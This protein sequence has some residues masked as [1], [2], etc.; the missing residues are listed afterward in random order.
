MLTSIIVL[1]F[2]CGA[3][4]TYELIKFRHDTQR[5]LSVLTEIIANNCTA[6][7]A[8]DD[9]YAA[10]EI[11]SA[12]KAKQHVLYANIYDLNGHLFAS[13]SRDD[14]KIVTG[15]HQSDKEIKQRHLLIERPVYLDNE[16]IGKVSLK[17]DLEEMYA[18]LT[19]YAGIAAAVFVISLLVAF[20]MTS[21]LQQ[22]ISKPIL[23]LSKIAKEVSEMKDY[24]IRAV[25]ESDDELG[26][27]INGFNEMLTQIQQRD[28]VLQKN[29]E[30]LEQRVQ[31]R[32]EA[33][34]QQILERKKAE[35]EKVMMQT[36][37]HQAQKMEA[38]GVLAGGVAHDFNNLLTAIQGCSNLAIEEVGED[39]VIYEDLKEIQM[40]TKRATDLT[41]QLLLF[42]RKQPMKLTVLDL[43]K[44]IEGLLSMLQRLLAEHIEVHTHFDPELWTI[45]GDR[46]TLEQ[47][48]MNLVVNA[49]DAMPKGGDVVIRTENVVVDDFYCRTVPEAR[50]GRFVRLSIS[51]T[52]YGMNK[53]TL[54]HVFEPFFTTKGMGKGTGLGLSVIYGIVME[55][56]GWIN[57]YSEVGKGSVFKIYFPALQVDEIIEMEERLSLKEFFGSGE[58]IL[59]VEDESNV[60]EFTKRALVKYGYKVFLGAN[61]EESKEVFREEGGQFDLIF[62]DVVLPDGNGVDLIEDFLREKP[63]LN[64]ILTSGYTENESN[65]SVISERGYPFLQKP[66]SLIELLRKI[67]TTISYVEDDQSEE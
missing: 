60:R 5:E 12:L 64:I 40:A 11:L 35:E 4:I 34:Q 54:K 6:A 23:H 2:V 3:F 16:V 42:S 46:G 20:G 37:L 38:I 47:T 15:S 32:T 30:E 17:Y 31:E 13:Y 43:N 10:E 45:E 7:L 36:Q 29:Q 50:I 59:V 26:V 14:L 58:R 56:N 25:K 44:T 39:H 57:V 51:D 27:L 48:V 21:R 61:A 22:I 62:S 9:Q 8:F 18:R 41:H 19:R 65:W 28:L 24:S 67:K 49:R 66:F 33:L 53:E 52:G 63:D 1:L 55:H